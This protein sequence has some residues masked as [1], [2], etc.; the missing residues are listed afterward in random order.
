MNAA[1]FMQWIALARRNPISVISALVCLS[2]GFICWYLASNMKWLDLEHK[3]L[4]Q[5]SDLAQAS[6]ISGPSVKQERLAALVVTRQIEDNLVIEDNLAE[7]LQYFYRI[8]DRSKCHIVEL[9]PLNSTMPDSRALFRRVP[10]SIRITGTYDQVILF[11]NGIETGPRLANITTLSV[12]RRDPASLTLIL[13]MSVE[14][15]GKR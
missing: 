12:R 5:D 4:M 7:N 1:D 15:L 11:L 8:E 14:L 9:R 6:L 2:C 10:F 13:D 3:Q